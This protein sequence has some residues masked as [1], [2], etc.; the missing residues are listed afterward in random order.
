M[1]RDK[2]LNK[3][4]TMI[5]LV[6]TIVIMLILAGVTVSG[7]IDGG[8][9]KQAQNANDSTKI[10][11]ERGIIQKSFIYAKDK[12][13]T[14]QVTAEDL[15]N[16]IDKITKEQIALVSDNGDTFTVK[17]NDTNNIYEVNNKGQVKGPIEN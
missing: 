16:E 10:A 9:F 1:K 5:S 6:I 14:G 13:R 3:G 17:F 12:S 4:I 2:R 8:L 15:Q 11:S 7:V